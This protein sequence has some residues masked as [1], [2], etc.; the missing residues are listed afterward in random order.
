MKMNFSQP[1]TTRVLLLAMSFSIPAFASPSP[2]PKDSS[3]A[4]EFLQD[5]LRNDR[6][7]DGSHLTA[8]VTN[9]VAILS[10]KASLLSQEQR[11]I[12]I[13][14]ALK[15][16]RAVIS[17]VAITATSPAD[18]TSLETQVRKTLETSPAIDLST[19][20][21]KVKGREAMVEGSVDSPEERSAVMQ[22]IATVSGIQQIKNTLSIRVGREIPAPRLE[23]QV[24]LIL[25]QDIMLQG[26]EFGI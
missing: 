1:W 26:L 3:E 23:A 4:V 14:E 16:V 2:G 17:E 25:Q 7:L 8:Q 18:E 20:T 21:V 19:V 15:G 22:L 9:G 12:R 24:A 10:G 11:A 13:A 6:E 5:N